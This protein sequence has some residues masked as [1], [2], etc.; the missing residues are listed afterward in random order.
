M[1]KVWRFVSLE[2]VPKH[3]DVGLLVLRLWVAGSLFWLHGLGKAQGYSK[4]ADKFPDPLG[5]GNQASLILAIIGEVVCPALLLLGLF[6]R[7]AAFATA[8]TMGV[9]FFMVHNMVLKPGPGSGELAFIYMAAF[10][11]LFIAGPGRYSLDGRKSGKKSAG[12][13]SPRPKKPNA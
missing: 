6:S 12:E 9:A 1:K 10:V 3:V 7:L 4:M 2:F 11:A 13:G 5:V 8:V